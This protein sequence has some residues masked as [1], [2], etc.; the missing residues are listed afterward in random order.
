MVNRQIPLSIRRFG[1]P[2]RTLNGIE[3]AVQGARNDAP[4]LVIPAWWPR[5]TF[6]MCFFAPGLC[7]RDNYGVQVGHTST[8]YSSLLESAE[9]T[10]HPRHLTM[11]RIACCL[12]SSV[13]LASA[14]SLPHTMA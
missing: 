12:T 9:L 4:G 14:S 8:C 13:V 3:E 1:P 7:L 10:P 6:T 11:E 2:V 5:Q